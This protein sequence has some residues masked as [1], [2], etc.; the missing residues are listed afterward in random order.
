MNGVEFIEYDHLDKLGPDTT[1]ND[2]GIRTSNDEY[3]SPYRVDKSRPF[4]VKVGWKSSKFESYMA[5]LLSLMNEPDEFKHT[6][7]SHARKVVTWGKER[8]VRRLVPKQ[9]IGYTYE[10][11][12]LKPSTKEEAELEYAFFLYAKSLLKNSSPNWPENLNSLYAL[13]RK[14]L[15]RLIPFQGY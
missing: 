13:T 14:G 11:V 1:K 10:K 3:Q 8:T 15:L 9:E 2:Y 6:Y 12:H 5:S 7:L 4:T